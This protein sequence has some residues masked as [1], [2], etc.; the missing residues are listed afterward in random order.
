MTDDVKDCVDQCV[1]VAEEKERLLSE[2]TLTAKQP[3]AA[4]PMTLCNCPECIRRYRILQVA[5]KCLRGCEHY[6]A[7]PTTCLQHNIKT[8][9]GDYICAP[10]FTRRFEARRRLGSAH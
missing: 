3:F 5:Q 1:D 10:T 9:A 8:K 2:V 7:A 6:V 4:Q